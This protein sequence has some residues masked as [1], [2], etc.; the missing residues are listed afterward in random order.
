MKKKLLLGGLVLALGLAGAAFLFWNSTTRPLYQPGMVRAGKNLSAP[1][2]PPPQSGEAGFWEMGDGV[3]LHH[4]SAGQG[5]PVL[6][7]H[8]GPGYPY[9]RAWTGLDPLTAA[10]EFIYY[11]QRGS[12]QSTRPIDRFES[13]NYYE[14]LTRLD[15]AL[16][17][18]TQLAD[19]ERIRRILG[20]EKLIL[21]GHS[22]GGFLASLYAAEFPEHVEALVLVAPAEVLVMP[23]V[24]GGLF[25]QVRARLPEAMLPDYDDW[26]KRYLDYGSI[27]SRSEDELIALN[28]AFG[29]YYAAVHPGA[30]EPQGRSGGW[31]VH[32]LFFSMGMRH[33]YRPA[34]KEV[35]APVLVL[36]GAGDL[37]PESAS[38]L[39][40]ES[41]AT[42]R[43]EVIE[44]ATHFAFE[45]QPE[46]FAEIVGEFLERVSSRGSGD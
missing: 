29:R 12:G 26:Q 8:G 46:R 3:R 36:H 5:R 13:G 11:D 39:Y 34:L 2:D 6:I 44:G 17:L 7:I 37:Q 31:M 40:A 42:A 24:S 38:R 21:I 45:E 32:A 1:L 14:N 41:F 25:A 19:I 35:T 43:F 20:Q 33:D 22:F 28:E 15:R 16:G 4:F 9:T 30:L 27:F 10:Y 18:G 23:S